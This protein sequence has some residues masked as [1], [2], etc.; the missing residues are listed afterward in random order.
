MLSISLNCIA[1]NKNRSKSGQGTIEVDVIA[2]QHWTR[3][4]VQLTLGQQ[5]NITAK[6]LI[7]WYAGS[8]CFLCYSSPN[9]LACPKHSSH[10][11]IAP[12]LKCYSLIGKIG[13]NGDTFQVGK[14]YSGVA[15][16]SGELQL[17]VN[18]EWFVDNT[19]KWRATTDVCLKEK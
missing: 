7:N 14:S 3:T 12:Q 4:G 10:P 16:S 5:V 19:G 2:N 6:G 1:Q 17:G 18:D 15:R 9:G 8:K 11:F 13:D